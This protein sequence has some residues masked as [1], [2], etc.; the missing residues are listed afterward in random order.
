MRRRIAEFL[1]YVAIVAI[2]SAAYRAL[3]FGT[4]YTGMYIDPGQQTGLFIRALFERAPL[5]LLA[6]F[7]EPPAEL[8]ALFGQTWRVVAWSAAVIL[9]GFIGVAIFPL[10]RRD[11]VARFWALWMILSLVPVC[12]TFPHNRLLLFPGIG[13]IGL[14]AQF[15]AEL[16]SLADFGVL[17][18]IAPLSR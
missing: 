4:Q 15:L 14:V 1:P 11:K 8:Y 3:G 10:L 17:R 12:A 9:V 5:L 18:E 2:W 13:A 16:R 7:A 6:Q